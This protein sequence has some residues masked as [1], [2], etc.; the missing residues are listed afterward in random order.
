MEKR[1]FKF[2][3]SQAKILCRIMGLWIGVFCGVKISSVLILYIVTVSFKITSNFA[4]L[5][6]LTAYLTDLTDWLFKGVMGVFFSLTILSVK[7]ICYTCMFWFLWNILVS[8]YFDR[9]LMMEV[10]EELIEKTG[11]VWLIC[12]MSGIHD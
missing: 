5:T 12:N 2:W 1:L 3:F 10:L 4:D 6:Y 8:T 11:N 7:Y 9:L